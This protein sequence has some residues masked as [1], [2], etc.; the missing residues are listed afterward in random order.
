MGGQPSF[1]VHGAGL[2]LRRP[3]LGAVLEHPP[4]VDFWELAPENWQGVGGAQGRQ[5]RSLTERCPLVCHGLCLSIGGP[6]PLDEAFLRRLRGFLDEHGA[7]A[8]TEHLSYCSDSGHLYDLLPIPFTEEAVRYVA[9]RVRR[10]QDILERPIALENVSYYVHP[11]GELSEI[12]FLEAVL[13]EADCGLHL[14]L[15]NLYVNSVNHG[16]DAE[17]FLDRVPGERIVYAHVAGH[18]VE[19]PDLR[20]DTHGAP[21]IDPVWCLLE[22]AYARFGVFPTLL[23]R[24]FNIPPLPRLL[25]EVGTIGQ[26]QVKWAPHCHGRAACG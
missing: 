8:Y 17:A 22:R 21:V 16:Y 14:D 24:D 25:E 1:P 20:V 12:D 15:N 5:L 13:A 3:F 7:R 2:G 26:L 23:E 4:T 9:A 11:G 18:Y 6:T 10:V 19:A